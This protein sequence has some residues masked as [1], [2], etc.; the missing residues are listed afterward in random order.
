VVDREDVVVDDA[1]YHVEDSLSSEQETDD[2]AQG[3]AVPGGQ[4]LP[5]QEQPRHDE[6]PRTG[7]EQPTRSVFSGGTA[8][9]CRGSW[10][11]LTGV[12]NADPSSI[13]MVVTTRRDPD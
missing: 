11:E 8:P 5:Q 6:H 13:R 10:W 9:S 3:G 2:A 7:V 12:T 4:G 1:R